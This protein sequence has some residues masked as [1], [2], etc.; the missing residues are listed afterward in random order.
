MSIQIHMYICG[1]TQ[2][3][4]FEHEI[5]IY[6]GGDSSFVHINKEDL[7]T[8]TLRNI[9]FND[10]PSVFTEQLYTPQDSKGS[11]KTTGNVPKSLLYTYMCLYICLCV[12]IYIFMYIY[13]Y[14]LVYPIHIYS[15]IFIYIHIYSCIWIH[16]SELN[17]W[18][19]LTENMYDASIYGI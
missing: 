13:L 2:I 1:S 10:S 3:L 7:L 9:T 5:S 16:C 18:V 8:S 14:L 19:Y 6:T 4:K 15:C 11:S 17:G 12:Y